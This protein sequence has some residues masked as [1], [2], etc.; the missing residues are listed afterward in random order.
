MK[1][2]SG[3]SD[4]ARFLKKTEISPIVHFLL[5]FGLILQNTA[6]PFH[7]DAG[8]ASEAN[9]QW[10]KGN[11]YRYIVVSRRKKTEIPDGIELVAVKEKDKTKAVFVQAGLLYN[12]KTDE[13]ELYCHSLD[14][15]K[16]EEG[17]KNKFQQRFEEELI[18]ADKALNLKSGTKR[19]EK[20]I[21]RIGRL[22]EKFKRVSH[23]YHITIDKDQESG[24]AKK[25][26]SEKRKRKR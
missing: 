2:D 14:K 11:H 19:Y 9:I 6:D 25:S 22:K 5:F 7:L 18:K 26:P 1:R 21:E 8:I 10:L 17:I 16:K 20:V 4:L 3:L 12:E 23:L 13:L 15:E 24:K